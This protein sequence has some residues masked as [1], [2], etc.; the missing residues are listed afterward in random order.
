MSSKDVGKVRKKD[1]EVKAMLS[2]EMIECEKVAYINE[3]KDYL[4]KLKNME[5]TQAKKI[6]F[7]NLVKS[8]IIEENGEFAEGYEFAR[9]NAQ[10]KRQ[11]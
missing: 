1:K 8:R 9:V 5:K 7:E 2:V 11:R 4:Q 6:S 10:K 3:M